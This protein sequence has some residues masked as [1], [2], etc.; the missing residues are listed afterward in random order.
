MLLLT[1]S[2][3]ILNWILC[4][5]LPCF[6]MI[7]LYFFCCNLNLFVFDVLIVPMHTI[8]FSHM[9]RL[10]ILIPLFLLASCA[11][12][13]G[14]YTMIHEEQLQNGFSVRTIRHQDNVRCQVFRGEVLV[15]E[16][17]VD[18]GNI[19]T[20]VSSY[21]KLDAGVDENMSVSYNGENFFTALMTAKEEGSVMII[22]R[23]GDG[24]PDVK[25]ESRGDEGR[26]QQIKHSLE[27]M[28]EKREPSAGENASRPTA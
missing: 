15:G 22:D 26:I 25:V 19:K 11:Q 6:K 4:V 9:K 18:D 12:K 24:F 2:T 1:H 5:M 13:W 20:V 23:D 3:H 17:D 7:L 8:I 27:A 14:V 21:Q 10:L 28:P 16:L